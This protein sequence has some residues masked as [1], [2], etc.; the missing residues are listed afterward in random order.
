MSLRTRIAI[1]TRFFIPTGPVRSIGAPMSRGL[2]KVTELGVAKSIRL[3]VGRTKGV[4]PHNRS[5]RCARTPATFTPQAIDE[6]FLELRK[7]QVD[8]ENAHA[9]GVSMAGWYEGKPE[10]SVAFE[11]GY[12]PSV[13]EPSYTVFRRNMNRLAEQLAE[14]FCQDSV[15]I[16][17]DSG[18][19]RSVAEAKWTPGRGKR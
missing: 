6:A 14:R 12:I 4:K 10:K 7:A 17:R 16:V 3:F 18:R 19:A 9:S 15:L 5:G 13:D 2:A 8:K 11:I 1:G